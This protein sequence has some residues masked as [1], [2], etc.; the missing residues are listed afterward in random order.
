M[1]RAWP[2][3]TATPLLVAP[4]GTCE[5]CG[6]HL[7][8]YRSLPESRCAPCQLAEPATE[9]VWQPGPVAPGTAPSIVLVVLEA[10]P[11]AARDIATQTGLTYPTVKDVL[12]RLRRQHRVTTGGPYRRPLYQLTARPPPTPA[13]S[14]HRRACAEEH[15]PGAWGTRRMLG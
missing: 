15:P 10:G 3:E 6:C 1:L 7:S 11:L 13:A 4:P 12:R 9:P 8:R 14:H 2:L 5:R